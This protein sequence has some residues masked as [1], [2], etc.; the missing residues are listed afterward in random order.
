[1]RSLEFNAQ[2][3]C[4]QTLCGL[5]TLVTC[6]RNVTLTDAGNS[7]DVLQQFAT[8]RMLL[9]GVQSVHHLHNCAVHCGPQSRQT[10]VALFV[11]NL[12]AG[13]SFCWIYCSLSPSQN[14]KS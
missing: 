1:M 3:E 11:Y 8:V 4:R 10:L 6:C 9:R 7:Y 13:I 2:I 5:V 12:T 14:N